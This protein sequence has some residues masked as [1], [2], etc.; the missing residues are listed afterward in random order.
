MIGAVSAAQGV[1]TNAAL[2]TTGTGK[3]LALLPPPDLSGLAETQDALTVLYA[4]RLEQGSVESRRVEVAMARQKQQSGAQLRRELAAME[5]ARQAEREANGLWAKLG[6]VAGTIAKISAVVAGAAAVVASGGTGTALVVGIAAVALSA[7][8]TVVRETKLLGKDS[9]SIG[10]GMEVAG[11]A[12]G[13]GGS[14]AAAV[15]VASAATSSTTGLI[16]TVGKTAQMAKAAATGTSAAAGIRIAHFD[17]D[18]EHARADVAD[19][20]F[21]M[22]ARRRDTDFLVRTLTEAKEA[23]REALDT[24]IKAIEAC[25]Q[26][27]DVAIAGVR[28]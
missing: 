22:A 11:V 23:E 15:G 2:P 6:S 27:A 3:V 17:A 25:N 12:I 20:Q 16:G 10:L 13:L 21:Q 26:A 9:D 8:G 7:G 18:A 1:R 19:A 4:F 14:V 24:T 5:A 28:G